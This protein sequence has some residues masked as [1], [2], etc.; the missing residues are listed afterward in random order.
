SPARACCARRIVPTC[1]GNGRDGEAARAGMPRPPARRSAW[2]SLKAL[3]E[4][5]S[6]QWWQR[7]GGS[8][9]VALRTKRDI[10]QLW[11]ACSRGGG[12]IDMVDKLVTDAGRMRGHPSSEGPP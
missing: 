3:A 4:P 5:R 8:A 6:P 12:E 7:C 1:A 11:Y 10:R 9:V 2:P